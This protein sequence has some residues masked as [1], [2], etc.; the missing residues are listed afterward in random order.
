MTEPATPLL[1]ASVEPA[2]HA[3]EAYTA[4]PPAEEALEQHLG[5]KAKLK[6]Q[7]RHRQ[8]FVKYLPWIAL[9]FMPVHFAALLL[10]LGITALA[11]LFGSFS[12]AGALLST[13][14]FVLYALALPGL[15]GKTR[16]GWAFYVY[17]LAVSALGSLVRLSLVGLL[18][19]AALL[20]V[21]FQVKYEYR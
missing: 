20:W 1:E 4:F 5:E 2:P 14:I 9:V 15:F 16:R 10:L 6:L 21:A 19:D 11:T 7:E 13:A 12:Y 3:F 17:A 18:L 8:G